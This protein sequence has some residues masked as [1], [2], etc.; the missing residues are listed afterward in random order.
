MTSVIKDFENTYL[1]L[2]NSKDNPTPAD[3]YKL[4]KYWEMQA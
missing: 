4:K 1:H 3:L 2:L